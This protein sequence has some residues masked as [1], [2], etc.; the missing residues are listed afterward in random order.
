MHSY[1]VTHRNDNDYDKRRK[2]GN[3]AFFF[4][5]L[6][7]S[8]TINPLQWGQLLARVKNQFNR[9]CGMRGCKEKAPV[10]CGRMEERNEEKII[11][12]ERVSEAK[13]MWRSHKTIYKKNSIE[14][15]T[16]VFIWLAIQS[17]RTLASILISS[18]GFSRS[19]A[20]V[21]HNISYTLAHTA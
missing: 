8:Y 16:T 1:D 9:N 14:L 15:P 17:E 21:V 10:N 3:F 11:I 19:R 12:V 20:D 18:F 5:F 4:S 6:S 2:H 13:S 7:K